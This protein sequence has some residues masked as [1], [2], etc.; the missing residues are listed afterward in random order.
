MHSIGARSADGHVTWPAQAAAVTDGGC[1]RVFFEAPPARV[2]FWV[3]NGFGATP[4][5][6]V[7]VDGVHVGTI[8][9]L[10]SSEP[11]C[12][13]PGTLT[14][15]L[16]AGLHSIYAS[17]S[18]SKTYRRPDGGSTTPLQVYSGRCRVEAMVPF[19]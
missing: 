19:R 3:G 6:D 18:N 7:K 14:L 11:S 9:Q 8:T 15:E 4:P 5:I 12:G 10:L 13:G 2:A 17:S 1:T 16:K